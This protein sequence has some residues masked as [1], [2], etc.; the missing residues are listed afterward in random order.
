MLYLK[1]VWQAR[2]QPAHRKIYEKERGEVESKDISR[3]IEGR[4]WEAQV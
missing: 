4:G 3:A 1:Q 2:P